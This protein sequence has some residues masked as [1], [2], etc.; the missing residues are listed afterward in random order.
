MARYILTYSCLFIHHSNTAWAFRTIFP[1]GSRNNSDERGESEPQSEGVGQKTKTM[2]R[3]EESGAKYMGF[4]FTPSG[5]IKKTPN[6]EC[7]ASK[8]ILIKNNFK[9][10][11]IKIWRKKKNSKS[12]FKSKMLTTVYR[13]SVVELYYTHEWVVALFGEPSTQTSKITPLKKMAKM[14]K[15]C[16]YNHPVYLPVFLR[17]PEADTA[18]LL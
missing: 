13:S 1:A 5:G 15:T 7:M 9:K 2:S 11:M 10:A 8:T 18:T 17:V 6:T 16:P 12:S 14:R 3:T 4:F